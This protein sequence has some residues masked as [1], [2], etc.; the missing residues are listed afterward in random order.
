M[1]VGRKLLEAERSKSKF[2][3]TLKLIENPETGEKMSKS[4]GTYVPLTA[5]PEDLFGKMMA[6]PDA[7]VWTLF[8]LVTDV[9]TEE[10]EALRASTRTGLEMRQAKARLA[11]EIVA[12]VHSAEAARRAEEA[13]N[14]TFVEKQP[15]HAMQTFTVAAGTELPLVALLL[16]LGAA[17]SNSEAVRLVRGGGVSIDGAR[18]TDWRMRLRIEHEMILKV[19]KKKFFR[20]RVSENARG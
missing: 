15:P 17:R 9:P 20:I 19:G 11:R 3:V 5:S 6:L 14:R 18:M 8:E 2:V 1:M 16:K 7:M 4:A 12:W 10:I 13:F